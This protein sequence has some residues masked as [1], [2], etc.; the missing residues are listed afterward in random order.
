MIKK[1]CLQ[2]LNQ[3][4]IEVLISKVLIDSNIIHYEFD[5]TNVLQEYGN[6]KAKITNLKF[7]TV[8][9]KF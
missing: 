3:N 4:R 6:M 2:N 5:L 8:Y 7:Y 9:Q 1:Y